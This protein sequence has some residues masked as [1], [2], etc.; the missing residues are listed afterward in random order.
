YRA[1]EPW[2]QLPT[3]RTWGQVST[4]EIDRDG[5]SVWVIDRCGS[6][7]CTASSLAPVLR[8]D[9][10]GKLAASFG[11]ELTVFPHGLSIDPWGNVWLTDA[12][13]SADK[14]HQVFKFSRDGKLLMVLG[15]RG[16]AGSGPDTFNRPSDVAVARNGT[17]YVADGHGAESNARIVKFSKDGKFVKAW[18]RKGA[19]P[20]ELDTPHALA[21]DSRGR[22]FVGDRANSR[23]QIFDQD[24]KLLD[25]WRQFGRPSGVFIDRNDMLYVADSQT[26]DASCGANPA[27]RQ[28]VRIGSAKDGVVRF[29]VPD[30]VATPDSSFGEGVAADTAGTLYVS[31]VAKRGLRRYARQ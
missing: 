12:N 19:G 11:A 8:F 29:Y 10:S 28:G 4:V 17:I 15:K 3:G 27:C 22:L 18:G 6:N 24:G 26:K 31:E 30:P 14:G 9:A 7:N 1:G 21:I 20:G 2:G 25:E 5:K 13:G 16:V 23:I